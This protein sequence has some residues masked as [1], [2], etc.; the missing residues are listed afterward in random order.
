VRLVHTEQQRH[1]LHP[2]LG[3]LQRPVQQAFWQRELF[4]VRYLPARNARLHNPVNKFIRML[5]R[6]MHVGG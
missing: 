2:Q 1:Q 5:F 4:K 6:K 3:L